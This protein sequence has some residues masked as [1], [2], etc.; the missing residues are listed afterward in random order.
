V[1]DNLSGRD[2]YGPE[3]SFE[4]RGYNPIDPMLRC[5]RLYVMRPDGSDVQSLILP[6]DGVGTFSWSPDS[7]YLVVEVGAVPYDSDVPAK[8]YVVSRDGSNVQEL[9]TADEILELDDVRRVEDMLRSKIG[10][11]YVIHPGDALSNPRPSWS[12]SGEYIRF[13]VKGSIQYIIHPDGSGIRR[14]VPHS[15]AQANL[16]PEYE[17]SPS[18]S[19][20]G[21]HVVVDS[22]DGFAIVEVESGELTRLGYMMLSGLQAFTWMPDGKHIILSGYSGGGK[23]D[24]YLLDIESRELANLTAAY[25]ESFISIPEWAAVTP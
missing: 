15:V 13:T 12:P 9:V 7:Q 20:D 2:T 23:Y 14:L 22:D 11:D 17:S 18:W 1:A 24:I 25:S 4:E 8:V 21:K 10:S 5:A 16:W 19:P 6:E 3:R